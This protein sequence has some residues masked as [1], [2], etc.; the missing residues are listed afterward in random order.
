MIKVIS[1]T[2]SLFLLLAC[3]PSSK[4]ENQKTSVASDKKELPAKLLKGLNAHGGLDSWNSF[5]TMEYS[6]PKGE[7]KEHQ[8]IDLKNRKVLISHP[9]YKVGFDGDEVWVSP[10]A[11]AFGKRSARFY[12]NLI[13]YFYAMPFVLADDGINY[14]LLT[15]KEFNGQLYDAVSIKY[16]S[17]VGDAP[18]DE[19]I[20]CFNKTTGQME[21]LMY[22]VTY[23]SKTKS[24][25]YNVIH[26]AEWEK[27]NGLK[28]PKK[29]VGYKYENGQLGEVRYERVFSN[30]SLS[31][32]K[33]EASFFAKPQVA[34]VSPLE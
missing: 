30:A 7:E 24:S 14:E 20:A 19:Y 23:Y 17:G 34:E 11:A 8:L 6:F 29:M 5:K 26:Y 13:F 31:S 10:N 25:K 12:H 15:D 28:L 22:T 9:N 21:Y 32:T 16:E 3:N 33:K 1:L 27:V 4:S 2:V 18:D